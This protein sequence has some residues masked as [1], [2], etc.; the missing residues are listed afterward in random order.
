MFTVLSFA[1]RASLILTAYLPISRLLLNRDT[2]INAYRSGN[3]KVVPGKASVWFAGP[4]FQSANLAT[5]KSN[6]R[7]PPSQESYEKRLGKR[8]ILENDHQDETWIIYL[9]R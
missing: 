2:T 4:L 8:A 9:D 7:L 3:F 5:V 1:L 6:C